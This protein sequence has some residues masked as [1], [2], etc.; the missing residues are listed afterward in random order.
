MT[1]GGDA[2]GNESDSG[3]GAGSGDAE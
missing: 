3:D 2:G 1:A